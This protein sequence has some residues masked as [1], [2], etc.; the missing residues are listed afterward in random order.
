MCF[1]VKFTKFV[2]T[3]FLTETIWWL[4]LRAPNFVSMSRLCTTQKN[5]SS[6]AKLI[7]PHN[8]FFTEQLP[9]AALKCQ[10]SFQKREKQKQ[11][12]IPLLTLIRLKSCNCIKIK[13]LFIHDSEKTTR[14]YLPIFSI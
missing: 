13:F 8:T 9:V 12:F 14:I 3:P 4:L 10:I 2:R 7:T 5:S 1:P 6:L 11:F